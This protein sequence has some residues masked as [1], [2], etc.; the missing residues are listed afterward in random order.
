MKGANSEDAKKIIIYTDGSSRGNPGAG[1][2]GA[3]ISFPNNKVVE[4]GGAEGHTTN[5]RMEL[6]AILKALEYLRDNVDLL[7]NGEIAE[8]N[9]DSAYSLN[10]ITKWIYGWFKNDWQTSEGK[11]VANKDLWE[12]IYQLIWFFK[13]KCEILFT[14]VSGHAGVLGNERADLIATAFADGD[15]ILLFTGSARDY[16]RLLGDTVGKR[17]SFGKSFENLQTQNKKQKEKLRSS[18]P[19]YSYV[20]QVGGMIER[21]QTWAECE[22]RVKGKSGAKFKKALSEEDEANIILSWTTGET[23]KK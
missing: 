18:Q 6:M 2:W 12:P 3:S 19:A 22:A 5:N 16:E 20:S 21:H 11:P 15:R 23:A 8:I 14:K 17:N 13:P 10:G 7:E 1:G 4:I 9:T